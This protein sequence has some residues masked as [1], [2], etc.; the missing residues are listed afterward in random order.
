M[1]ATNFPLYLRKYKITVALPAGNGQQ[2][3][4]NIA[5]SDQEP[6]AL[7]VRFF[8]EQLAWR[9]YWYADIEIYNLDQVTTQLLLGQQMQSLEVTVQAGYQQGAFGT[10]WSGPVYQ[11]LF[12]RENATDFK[13][14]LHCILGLTELSRNFTDQTFASEI[15]QT[16]M[17]QQIAAQAFT[18]IPVDKVSS[19]LKSVK[20][21][22]GKTVFGN[23]TKYF[24]QIAEDN[25]MAWWLGKTGL[26]MGT[27]DEDID[28]NIPP[29]LTFAP[30]ILPEPN[31][32][33][34]QSVPS[35]GIIVGT[36]V[37]TQYGVSFRALLNPAVQVQK[38]LLAVKIDNTQIRRQKL[39][40]GDNAAKL[41][42]LDQDGTYI[43]GGTR[44]IGDTRG[45]D[46][47]VEIDGYAISLGRM[48]LLQAL[49]LANI[50]NG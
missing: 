29:S 37:Q 17:L 41:T 25:N 26:A 20:L 8:I 5:S 21:P 27:P 7:R 45:N 1:S 2:T 4:I 24:D 50:T 48:Q 9:V 28:L 40:I 47:Y 13:I 22:R 11:A 16:E 12:D 33:G 49:G 14:T 38:P 39:V 34:G 3:V 35:N 6:R 32:A 46:W 19:D 43:V 15:T 23:P 10:I 30:P 31:L 44:F 18:R 42:F 36:P